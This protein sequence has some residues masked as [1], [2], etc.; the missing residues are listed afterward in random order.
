MEILTIQPSTEELA[1]II[2]RLHRNNVKE[3]HALSDDTSEVIANSVK[4]SDESWV[5]TADGVPAV[6]Y[7]VSRG[8]ALSRKGYPWLICTELINDVGITFLRQFRKRVNE[9]KKEFSSMESVILKENEEVIKMLEW[10]G[11]HQGKA[12]THNGHDFIK[13]LWEGDD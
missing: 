10:V 9:F 8:S 2:E 5:V 7:G 3:A 11:F 12:L 4:N 6:V 13:M 1:S